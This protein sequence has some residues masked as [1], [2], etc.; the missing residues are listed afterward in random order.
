MAGADFLFEMFDMIVFFLTWFWWAILL[1]WIGA[2]KLM[3]KSWMIE[4]WIFEKRGNNLIAVNDRAGKF[5]DPYTSLINYRLQKSKDAIPVPE[6]DHLLA[7]VTN[8]NTILERIVNF[9]RGNAGVLVLFRYGTKQYKP[10]KVKTKEGM[11]TEFI[12]IKDKTGNFKYI[13]TYRIMDPRDKLEP[14]DFEVVDW[15][16]MN[17]MVQ[18]QRASIERRKKR[19]EFWKQIA[20]PAI[21]IGA[22][23][24]FCIIM[25]K[26]A[27]DFAMNVKST[28]VPQSTQKAEVPNIPVINQ[29]MPG[30]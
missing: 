20:I 8:H 23:V 1:V 6:Y 18:E 11:K 2:C 19:S 5:K 27:F 12:S 10:I 22:A 9:I 14:L 29:V 16:N 3:W 17:F 26:F 7:K 30:Q 21:M 25:I 4:T 13:N 28:Q 15:D 24:I